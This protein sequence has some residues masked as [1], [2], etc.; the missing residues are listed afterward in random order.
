MTKKDGL[1]TVCESLHVEKYQLQ[2]KIGEM[3]LQKDTLDK[4]EK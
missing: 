4:S 1:K 2:S 3:E